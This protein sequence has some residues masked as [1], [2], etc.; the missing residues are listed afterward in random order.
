MKHEPRSAIHM[1]KPLWWAHK[2]GGEESLGI[3]KVGQTL[4]ARLIESQIW[5]QPTSSM[6]G[7]L[8]KETTTSAVLD[9]RHF[10]FSLSTGALQTATP[11]L[12][13]KG[14]ESE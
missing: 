6:G 5:H 11:V 13:L 14:S 9:A 12:E 1:E 4:L 3:S 2:L 8:S 7:G 10:S